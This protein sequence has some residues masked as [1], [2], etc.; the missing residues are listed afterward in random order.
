LATIGGLAVLAGCAQDAAA[1]GLAN[2]V[3]DLA[4]PAMVLIEN[5]GGNTSMQYAWRLDSAAASGTFTG[6]SKISFCA[7]PGPCGWVLVRG[8]PRELVDSLMQVATSPEFRALRAFYPDSTLLPDIG[9]DVI[10]VVA[11]GRRHVVSGAYPALAAQL[12]ARVKAVL[13]G[14]PP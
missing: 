4:T 14:P 1:P 7:P 3:P 12:A 6:L 2:D 13:P 11:N 5:N 8:E 10:T 9:Y